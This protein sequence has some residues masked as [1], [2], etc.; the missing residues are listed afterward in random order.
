[1]EGCGFGGEEGWGQCLRAE[2]RAG[3]SGRGYLQVGSR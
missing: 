3:R 2:P 1:M